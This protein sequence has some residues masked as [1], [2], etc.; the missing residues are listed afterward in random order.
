MKKILL[1]S[2]CIVFVKISFSFEP[3]YLEVN[4]Q[5]R[6][7]FEASNQIHRP[8]YQQFKTQLLNLETKEI[9]DY[10]QL[11]RRGKDD[12][13]MLYVAGGIAIATTTLILTNNPDNFISNSAGDVNT[14][15]AIGGGIACALIITKYIIDQNR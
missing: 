3:T 1:L 11:R 8:N 12:Y 6:K 14:G 2:I 9:Q 5:G 10:A 15:I 4:H 7:S 13:L